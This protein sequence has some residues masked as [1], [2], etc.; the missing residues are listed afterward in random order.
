MLFAD[1]L[2]LEATPSDCL[3]ARLTRSYLNIFDGSVSR[4][5]SRR[6]AQGE[7]NPCTS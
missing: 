7:Q 5:Q 1:D 2:G 6:A 4:A 3:P